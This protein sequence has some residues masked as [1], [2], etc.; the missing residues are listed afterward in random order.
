MQPEST[1]DVNKEFLSLQYPINLGYIASSLITAGHEVEMIDLNVLEHKKLLEKIK[2]FKPEIVGVTSM[3]PNIYLAQKAIQESKSENKKIKTLLG[4]VHASALPEETMKMIKELDYLVFG[5]GEET[6]KELAEKLEKKQSVNNVKGILYRSKGRI[7]KNAPRPLIKNLDSIPFPE[8][9]LLPMDLYTKHHV[10]RGFSRENMK[11]MEILTSRGCP[12]QCIFCAGHIN[13][14]HSLRFRSYEN[15]IQEINECIRK[16]K[17]T[18]VSIEDDTFTINKELVKKLCNFFKNKKLTWNCNARV[19]TVNYE[20]LKLMKES[21]CKKISFGVESGSEKILK[22]IKKGITIPQVKKAVSDA[23]KA[24]IRYV[25]CTFMIGSHPD[26][27]MEDIEKTIKLMHEL[28]PDFLAFSV[29]CPFPGTEVY[30]M[31]KK[32]K[33][34]MNNPDWSQFSLFG[35]LKRYEKLTNMTSDEMINLQ[36]KV[37]KD[38]YKTPKYVLSQLLKIRT[39]DEIKYFTKMG[40]L[41]VKE[42]MLGKKS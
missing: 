20:I 4:G 1:E 40:I 25:E 18:H 2:K 13:Y 28:M 33:L 11:I 10:S 16:Y 22:L 5:E 24:G 34:L 30:N 26:E 37:L 32:R 29:M 39:L 41:Y 35:N 42:L 27:T 15:I 9:D 36:I 12:N 3:T 7:I 23:K 21:G 17:I 6:I 14:G 19:N 38:Y 8:R 31:M